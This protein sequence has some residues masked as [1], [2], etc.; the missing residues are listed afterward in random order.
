MWCIQKNA[1]GEAYRK[2][3]CNNA[4]PIFIQPACIKVSCH[5]A[6]DSWNLLCVPLCSEFNNINWNITFLTDTKK[7]NIQK[8]YSIYS[9]FTQIIYKSCLTN[10][11]GEQSV[12]FSLINDLCGQL[13]H[14]RKYNGY[15]GNE[16]IGIE[17]AAPH[18]TFSSIFNRNQ[19]HHPLTVA[20]S[21]MLTFEILCTRAKHTCSRHSVAECPVAQLPAQRFIR[22]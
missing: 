9:N 20:S 4:Q 22:V 2:P 6:V 13:K 15:T 16:F 10:I 5:F 19:T 8:N 21:I 18:Q 1:K 3:Q 17:T 11:S 7:R 14:E 12:A